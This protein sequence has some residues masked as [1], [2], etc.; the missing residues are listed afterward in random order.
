MQLLRN[1]DDPNCYDCCCVIGEL[2]IDVHVYK[3]FSNDCFHWYLT[4]R[5]DERVESFW[6]T[7]FLLS[8]V[9]EQ[10]AALTGLEIELAK[11]AV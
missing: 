11:T 3:L 5:R 10:V 7:S 6:G 4:R 1:P 2:H 9:A 8:E